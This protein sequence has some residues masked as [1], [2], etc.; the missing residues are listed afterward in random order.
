M[1]VV[2]IASQKGGVGKTSVALNLAY[3]LARRGRRTLLVDVDPQGAVGLSLARHR[4]ELPGL[5]DYL[6]EAEAL[7]D[8]VLT[9]RLDTLQIVPIGRVP[10]F[11]TPAFEG[12]LEDGTALAGLVFEAREIADYVIF[13]TPSG[14]GGATLGSLRVCTHVLSTLQTEPLSLRSATQ[15][16]EVVAALRAEGRS[17]TFAGFVPTMIQPEDEASM[18]VLEAAWRELPRT[19]IFRTMVPRDRAFLEAS[20]AGVPLALLRRHPPAVAAVFDQLAAELEA[21][22]SPMTRYDDGEP[23]SLLS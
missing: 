17:T 7:D 19:A 3:S 16:L 1:K 6:S 14:F 10:V 21:R 22:V 4:A 23:V 9:T 18:T 2:T 13:D 11:E 20:T 12:H 8:Y 5:A 15:M